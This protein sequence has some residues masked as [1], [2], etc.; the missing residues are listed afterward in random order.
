MNF[1]KNLFKKKVPLP[2]ILTFCPLCKEKYEFDKV[3]IDVSL[4]FAEVMINGEE[5]RLRS[6]PKCRIILAV[7][8]E[9]S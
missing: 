7:K 6:C 1:F 3:W 9:L 8:S 4:K 5:G 2:P